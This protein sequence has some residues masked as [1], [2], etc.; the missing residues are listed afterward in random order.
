MESN[1]KEKKIVR[2]MVFSEKEY[3]E[4][5]RYAEAKM[6]E[7]KSFLKFAAKAYMK[8]YPLKTKKTP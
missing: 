1:T 2:G 8:K 3:S 4:I 6:L 7:V 5:E